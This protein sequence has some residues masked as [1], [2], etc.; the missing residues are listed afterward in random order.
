MFSTFADVTVAKRT[1]SEPR[2]AKLEEVLKLC[3]GKEECQVTFAP[4]I[5]NFIRLTK[6]LYL[7]DQIDVLKFA[8]KVFFFC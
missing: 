3:S 2:T 1:Y 4:L 8:E 5:N 6:N 7:Q